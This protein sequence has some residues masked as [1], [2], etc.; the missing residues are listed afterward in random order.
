MALDLCFDF[1]FILDLD[2]LFILRPSQLLS[3]IL[4]FFSHLTFLPFPFFHVCLLSSSSFLL[5][6]LLIWCLISAIFSKIEYENLPCNIQTAENGMQD[7]PQRHDHKGFHILYQANS[8]TPVD[9]TLLQY[10]FYRIRTSF[11]QVNR[12]NKRQIISRFEKDINELKFMIVISSCKVEI[13]I[14]R[15]NCRLEDWNSFEMK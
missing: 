12:I 13:T 8:F 3:S 1:I 5:A 2:L 9:H 15:R 14:W 11:I 4:I 10:I 7:D 6:R